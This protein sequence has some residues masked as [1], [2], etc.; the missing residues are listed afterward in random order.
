MPG[1]WGLLTAAVV[2]GSLALAACGGDGSDA[3]A[4]ASANA[5]GSDRATTTTDASADESTTIAPSTTTTVPPPYSF[6]GSVPPPPLNNTGDD[7]EAI[8]RSLDAYLLWIVAHRPDRSLVANI[9]VEGS[10]QYETYVDDVDDLLANN[11]R[12]YDEQGG[13]ATSVEVVSRA[14]QLVTLKVAYGADRRVIVDSSG[15]TLDE[16]ERLPRELAV[17]MA[18]DSQGR[19]R[20]VSVTLA[21]SSDG[22]V[23]L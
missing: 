8:A 19:W 2:A 1:R 12:V 23:M 18:S 6:D 11:A 3:S 5:P 21:S 10:E 15:N 22:G 7:F 20:L 14:N 16:K 17:L 13:I 4:N 9:A